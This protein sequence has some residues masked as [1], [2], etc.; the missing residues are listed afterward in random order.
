MVARPSDMIE[1]AKYCNCADL[2]SPGLFIVMDFVW[3]KNEEQAIRASKGVTGFSLR[4][5]MFLI[6]DANDRLLFA[7]KWP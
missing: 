5:G 7:M 3:A 6:P 2:D 1:N 4:D